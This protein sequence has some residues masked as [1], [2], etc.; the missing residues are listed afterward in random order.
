MSRSFDP[1]LEDVRFFLR[2]WRR[3]VQAWKA[4]LGLSPAVNWV[5]CMVPYVSC[6]ETIC[7]EVDSII[8]RCVD[9]AVE[10]LE[11]SKRAALRIVYL[12]EIGPAVFRSGRMERGEVRRLCDEAERDLIPMLRR[13]GVVFGG[14]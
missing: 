13:K 7:D 5:S 2:Q 9:A 14:T 1:A 3:W 6:G 11:P 8:M 4:P 12:N 10:S